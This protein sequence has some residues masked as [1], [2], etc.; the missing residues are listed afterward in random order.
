MNIFWQGGPNGTMNTLFDFWFLWSFWFSNA[1]PHFWFLSFWKVF[2]FA[3]L[4]SFCVSYL[5]FLI[6][7]SDCWNLIFEILKFWT[8]W[9]VWNLKFK[10]WTS[11][12]LKFE[13]RNSKFWNLKFENLKFEILTFLNLEILEIWNF[14]IWNFEIWNF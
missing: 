13:I 2:A 3:F 14:E 8:L 6:C 12:I 9:K 7:E 4:Q 11:E 5:C 10:F 1:F